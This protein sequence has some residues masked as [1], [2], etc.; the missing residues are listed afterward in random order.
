MSGFVAF[1]YKSYGTFLIS[2]SPIISVAELP[3]TDIIELATLKARKRQPKGCLV[4]IS[5]R[6]RKA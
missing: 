5:L 3:T 4:T 1:H 2:K 6:L